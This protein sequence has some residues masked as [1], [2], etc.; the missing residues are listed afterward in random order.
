V[1]GSRREASPESVSIPV[2]FEVNEKQY[3][4]LR[5]AGIKTFWLT[6]TLRGIKKHCLGR[7]LIQIRKGIQ[8][9]ERHFGEFHAARCDSCFRGPHF[10]L[11]CYAR[12]RS[13]SVSEPWG[14]PHRRAKA[15][16]GY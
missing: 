5:P 11:V 8:G 3:W 14:M 9:R 10:I 15:L 12:T 2:T 6:K 16:R 13:R 4:P 7:A 1:T